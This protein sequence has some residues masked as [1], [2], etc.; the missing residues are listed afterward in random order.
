MALDFNDNVDPPDGRL[1]PER[2]AEIR[3]LS[4][5]VEFVDEKTALLHMRVAVLDLLCALDGIG[6]DPKLEERE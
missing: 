4:R 1:S 2:L 6:D 5:C 3:E